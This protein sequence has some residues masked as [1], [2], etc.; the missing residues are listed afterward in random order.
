MPSVRNVLIVGGG[1]AGNTLAILLR[2]SGVEVDLVEIDP[3]W[4]ALGSGITLVGNALRVL[5]EVGVWDRVEANIAAVPAH[6]DHFKFGGPDVP[7]VCG[8]YRPT[9]QAILKDAV[10]HSGARV[11]LGTTVEKL[12]ETG[13]RVTVTLRDGTVRDYDLVV[14]ADGIHS[15]TRAMIGIPDLPRPTGLAIWRVYIRRPPGL[16]HGAI[17]HGGPHHYITGY[18]MVSA[19][20]MYAYIFEDA[21]DRSAVRRLDPVAEFR[22]L[23]EPL[24]GVWPA[25]RE[26]VTEP[27][28]VDYRNLDYLLIDSPWNRGRTIVIGDAA[29]ALSLIQI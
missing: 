13:D 8:M 25:I 28:Q 3:E 17:Q 6:L 27:R 26:S 21:R 16:E 15:A 1:T 11:R 7:G 12:E 29:H 22:R 9:L 20:H 4:G 5:R 24:D 23:A 18:N 19:T 10:R 14:G 2:R